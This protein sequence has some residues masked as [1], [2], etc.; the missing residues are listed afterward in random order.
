MQTAVKIKYLDKGP[1]LLELIEYH[2][3]YYY[4]YYYLD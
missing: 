2:I 1:D 4:Y 3:Y